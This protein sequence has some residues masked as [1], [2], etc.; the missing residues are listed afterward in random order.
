MSTIRAPNEERS[1]YIKHLALNETYRNFRLWID[2]NFAMGT[3]TN[4]EWAEILRED[5]D[6]SYFEHPVTTPP[7]PQ[8]YD[9]FFQQEVVV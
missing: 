3:P 6:Y 2:A 7:P 1:I 8:E 5:R 4:D 9:D